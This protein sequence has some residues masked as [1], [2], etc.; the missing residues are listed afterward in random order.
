MTHAGVDWLS[1]LCCPSLQQVLPQAQCPPVSESA[2]VNIRLHIQMIMFHPSRCVIQC[3]HSPFMYSSSWKSPFKVSLFLTFVSEDTSKS[4]REWDVK[5]H[6]PS[7]LYHLVALCLPGKK[8]KMEG[9]TFYS[10]ASFNSPLHV[11]RRG[12]RPTWRHVK[13]RKALV[14]FT[15]SPRGPRIPEG[16][17]WTQNVWL[18]SGFTLST[19]WSHIERIGITTLWGRQGLLKEHFTS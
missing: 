14:A 7:L 18:Y 10:G 8:E 1:L 15:F 12:R 6:T 11:S 19:S 3:Y 2:A 5:K 4:A 16:P 9:K 17:W 13:M